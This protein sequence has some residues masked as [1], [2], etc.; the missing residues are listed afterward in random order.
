VF[1]LSNDNQ[2]TSADEVSG[3]VVTGV[4]STVGITKTPVWLEEDRGKAY[5]VMTG[6]G[7]PGG[8]FM[9]VKNKGGGG[10][11]QRVYWMQIQ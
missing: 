10:A 9:S 3:Q 6:T 4:R 11:L 1:D 7:G 8:L 2:F 5:K